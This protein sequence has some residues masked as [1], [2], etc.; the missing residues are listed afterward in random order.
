MWGYAYINFVS[1]TSM[2]NGIIK[3]ISLLR[4]PFSS[5]F[6]DF[7][8]LFWMNLEVWCIFRVLFGRNRATEKAVLARNSGKHS[9]HYVRR[10][11]CSQK[12]S[13]QKSQ[14]HKRRS[15]NLGVGDLSSEK[16]S[17]QRANF[18]QNKNKMYVYK[19]CNFISLEKMISFYNGT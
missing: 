8:F 6:L 12:K 3:C 17:R 9:D 7:F 4:L 2:C 19:N 10:W 5:F 1:S 13:S 16:E 18:D 14:A 11:A 15:F